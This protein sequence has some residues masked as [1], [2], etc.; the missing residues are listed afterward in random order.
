M[1]LESL[2]SNFQHYINILT[3]FTLAY[4]V[5]SFPTGY[6]LVKATRGKD[7][8]EIGSGSTGA[9]NVKRVLGT[10]AFILVMFV[11]GLKG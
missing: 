8:R 5:G 10:W 11:D 3:I 9:T 1:D 2:T 7:I 4:F 6:I